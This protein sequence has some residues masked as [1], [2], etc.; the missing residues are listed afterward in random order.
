MNNRAAYL[1]CVIFTAIGAM[2]FFGIAAKAAL[3]GRTKAALGFSAIGAG[4]S[5]LLWEFARAR[6]EVCKRYFIAN[7]QLMSASD[8]KE[9]PLSLSL[10]AGVVADVHSG[11]V[12]LRGLQGEE[13]RRIHI[14]N[15][16]IEELRA[17]SAKPRKG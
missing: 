2:V 13:L 9:M 5:W 1:V 4:S 11:F 3:R 15:P 7:G 12:S 17:Y 6:K 14:D 10:V 16:V 8:P